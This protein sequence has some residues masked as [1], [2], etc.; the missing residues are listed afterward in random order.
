[1]WVADK[2][3][4]EFLTVIYKESYS[5][6]LHSEWNMGTVCKLHLEHSYM[7]SRKLDTLENRSELP[8]NIWNVVLKKDGEDHLDREI[9]KYYM[10]SQRRGISYI[11]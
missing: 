11:Q 7:W 1:M 4:L 2:K 5:S 10:D 3:L 9:K 6:K 8:G